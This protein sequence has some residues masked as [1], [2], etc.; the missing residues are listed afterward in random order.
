MPYPACMPTLGLK[1]RKT[2]PG[3]NFDMRV[4][5][6]IL[7]CF[8]AA[9][10]RTDVGPEPGGATVAA[11][12]L[13]VAAASSQGGMTHGGFGDASSLRD[14]EPAARSAR[15]GV[16]ADPGKQMQERIARFYAGRARAEQAKRP[17]DPFARAA[18]DAR[19]GDLVEQRPGDL[20]A[21]GA[22][23]VAPRG[24]AIGIVPR[25]V[26][27]QAMVS[28][29]ERFRTAQ[30]SRSDGAAPVR[31]ASLPGVPAGA[32]PGDA[33]GPRPGDLAPPRR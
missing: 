23:P 30:L 15:P 20:A 11:Q 5:G 7:L 16:A 25:S 18:P 2:K 27:D 29:I 31:P 21:A 1:I 33:P 6:I 10:E 12:P 22:A 14:R 19:A 3:M 24:P 28:R 9:C 13:P 8:L 26:P 17:P 4:A 32:R